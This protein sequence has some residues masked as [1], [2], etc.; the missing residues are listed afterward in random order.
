MHYDVKS[1]STERLVRTGKESIV[2]ARSS[3]GLAAS[4]AIVAGSLAKP[5]AELLAG[6][7]ING[8]IN[9]RL[10]KKASPRVKGTKYKVT[11]NKKSK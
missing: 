11:V 2:A 5:N 8:Y 4:I 9:T 1:E 6:G 10:L 7:S 3:L